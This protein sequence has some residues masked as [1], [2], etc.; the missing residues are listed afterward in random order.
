MGARERWYSVMILVTEENDGPRYLRRG[1][2]ETKEVISLQ[3]AIKRCDRRK[4]LHTLER[5][6]ATVK[7]QLK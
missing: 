7:E 4:I 3:D 2:E 1:P 5:A 6:V